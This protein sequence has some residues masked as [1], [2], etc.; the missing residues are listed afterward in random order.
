MRILICPDKFK[1]S[2]SAKQ[3]IDHTSNGILS[4]QKNAEIIAKPLADGGEGSLDVITSLL[5]CK[6]VKVVVKDPLFRNVEAVYLMDEDKNAY[7]E[8][9][10]ASGLALLADKEMDCM[11]TSSY[12]TG[13]LIKHAA[14]H[15]AK[16]INLFVGG[17]A[18]C[19][20][21]IGMASALGYKFIDSDRKEIQ[22][23]GKNLLK[24]NSIINPDSKLSI[25]VNVLVDVNNPFHG[26]DGAAHVFSPQKG[27]NEKEVRHLDSGLKNL[28]AIVEDMHEI[29]LQ[30]IK[31]SG[32]AGGIAGG[33]YVFLGAQIV[34]GFEFMSELLS[35]DEEVKK[36]DLV[37][38]GEGKVDSQT[39]EGKVVSGVLEICKKHNKK[40]LIICGIS[41]S[42]ATPQEVNIIQLRDKD[43]SVQ[44]ALSHAGELLESKIEE[45][46]KR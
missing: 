21:G 16:N 5:D 4:S 12:G 23:I 8:M 29:D 11:Y 6:R 46:F 7:I 28:S 45:Y 27:A 42:S 17:S 36:A 2:L 3:V 26:I 35:L 13:Q 10:S 44:Y 43:M 1:G 34:S 14:N 41:E 22:P 15:G 39:W 9:A 37:I 32:A 31:G 30:L 24:I 25:N 38:T 40:L 20:G 33:T 18:T 19:D